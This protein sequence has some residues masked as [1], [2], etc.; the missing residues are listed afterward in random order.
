M[1]RI[2]QRVKPLPLEEPIGCRCEPRDWPEV[3]GRT[4]TLDDV[5]G[6]WSALITRLEVDVADLN[7]LGP[8]EAAASMGRA[9]DPEW[10]IC[11]AAVRSAPNRIRPGGERASVAAACTEGG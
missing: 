5:D 8:A 7:G 3:E 6:I 9:A 4:S 10:R 2:L 11:K 1:T